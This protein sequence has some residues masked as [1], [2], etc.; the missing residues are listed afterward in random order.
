M[1][2]PWVYEIQVEGTIA[3][4]WSDWFE[5]LE[6]DINPTGNTTLSGFLI[7]Q[8]ALFGVLNKI[9]SLNLILISVSRSIFWEEDKNKS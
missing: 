8:A 7:D 4:R 3:G 2:K 1:D 9:H 5:G 6:I